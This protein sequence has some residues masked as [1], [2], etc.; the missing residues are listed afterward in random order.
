MASVPAKTAHKPPIK[1]S[2][3]MRVLYFLRHVQ[4]RNGKHGTQQSHLEGF[5]LPSA[6][7]TF[8]EPNSRKR[9]NRDLSEREFSQQKQQVLTKA[10]TT[11]SSLFTFVRT[12]YLNIP[13]L[14]L[15]CRDTPKPNGNPVFVNRINRQPLL[16]ATVESALRVKFWTGIRSQLRVCAECLPSGTIS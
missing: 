10:I 9:S 16:R 11:F 3:L 4:T 15:Q 14:P 12:F 5:W 2:A 7:Q 13:R 1:I 8:R 6:A